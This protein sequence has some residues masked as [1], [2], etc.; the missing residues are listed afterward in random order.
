MAFDGT[1]LV[2]FNRN[3]RAC[4]TMVGAYVHRWKVLGRTC[5][6]IFFALVHVG[7]PVTRHSKEV[8]H[9]HR[10]SNWLQKGTNTGALDFA[11]C[12]LRK[13]FDCYYLLRDA[14]E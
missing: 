8:E 14:E 4:E 12:C 6:G 10:L 9:V 11:C 1:N 3:R 13:P 2:A 5:A 7:T